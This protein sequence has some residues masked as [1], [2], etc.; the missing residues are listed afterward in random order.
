FHSESL[1]AKSE[2]ARADWVGSIWLDKSG[3][4]VTITAVGKEVQLE[5]GSTLPFPGGA[6]GT[7]PGLHGILDIDMNYDLKNDLVFAGRGG[8]RMF[9]Q[10]DNG[11][12]V[13]VTAK[14]GLPA[15]V[16]GAAYTGAWSLDV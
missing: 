3:G 15:A 9:Q 16:L 2:A 8:V 4:R 12:F 6:E 7:P 11:K 5:N 1:C 14:S 13:D 10:T